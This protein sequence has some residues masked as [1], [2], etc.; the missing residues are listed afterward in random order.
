[1]KVSASILC[2]ALVRFPCV[3]QAV[4]PQRFSMDAVLSAPF[5]SNLTASPDGSSLAFTADERGRSNIYFS[6]SGSAARHLTA[7][8]KD[9]GQP[10][11]SVEISPDNGAVVFVRGEGTNDRGEYPN[12]LSLPDPPKQHVS[13][14]STTRGEPVELGEGNSPTI[15]PR[16]DRVVWLLH[17]QPFAA[18][19]S[20]RGPVTATRAARLFKV[21]GNIEGPVFS[22]DGSRI[23]FSNTRGDH[24]FVV[25]YDFG[26]RTL[27]YA[28]AAFAYDSDPAW[29]PDGTRV[30]FIRSPAALEEE[31][32]YTDPLKEPWSIWVADAVN[33]SAKRVFQADA[34]MG[35]EYYGTAGAAQLWWGASGRIAFEWERDGWRHLYSVD[36]HGGLVRLLTPGAFEV[37][38]VSRSFGQSLI[39]TSNQDDNDRRH[40]WSVSLDGSTPVRLSAG[41]H[42]QWN[43]I[44]MAHGAAY[45]DAGYARPPAVYVWKNGSA[46]AL[47]GGPRETAKFPSA[48][49]VEPQLVTFKARDGLTIHAQLFVP[50]DGLAKHCGIIFNHGG[51]RRQMLPGF[52]YMETYTNFYESNQ[53][54]ANHG[55]DVLSINYRSGIMYGHDFR[56][57]KDYGW[58]GAAEYQDVLAGAAF[59]RGRSEVDGNRLGIYGLSYGGYLT[60]L[61]LARSSDVFKA[62]VDM[63]GVH[64]WV[65]LRDADYSHQ[66]GTPRERQIAF[67]ASPI[68]SIRNWR[69]PVFISQ[70]D[71]DRNVIFS[72]G[73]DLATRLRA[74]G[75]EVTQLVFPNETHENVTYRDMLRLYEDSSAWLLQKLGE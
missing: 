35:Q 40:I 13:I 70:G 58:K 74:L 71:D 54:Y 18:H 51:S 26:K 69:S 60:A 53:Y 6:S 46:R 2:F 39:Y 29:S 30:A 33:G 75:V 12:P 62:G 52:H 3:A 36:P 64:N 1:M 8:M 57:A 50:K 68:A 23:A 10:L 55:C 24:G 4:A 5:V 65:T 15:S 32:P 59:L 25:I 42:N 31:D 72:Q 28:S 37:E 45:I 63:A 49:L 20:T 48:A 16:G 11:G 44:P 14:V 19:I 27:T 41:P 22:R 56:E 61:A 43:P 66:V 21:R 67:D 34:G 38:S 47:P 73:V 7:Y 9:D 17:G